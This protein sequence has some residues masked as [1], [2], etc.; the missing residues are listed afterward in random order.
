MACRLWRE[1]GLRE[2]GK[3]A[4]LDWSSEEMRWMESGGW[5]EGVTVGSWPESLGRG[6]FC[7]LAQG[8]D[9]WLWAWRAIL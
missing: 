3:V 1:G 7:G 9:A 6:S 5:S 2:L 4:L 8:Q